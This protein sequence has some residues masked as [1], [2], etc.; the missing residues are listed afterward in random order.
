MGY[1][2]LGTVG[3]AERFDYGAVG[4]VPDVA[5]RLAR[6]AG[7]GQILLTQRVRWS[8]SRFWRSA[9]IYQDCRPPDDREIQRILTATLPSP[10]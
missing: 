2:T 6:Q 10:S 5:A 7:S 3:F 9:S 8:L 1:A 4:L